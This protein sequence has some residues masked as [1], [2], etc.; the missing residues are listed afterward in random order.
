MVGGDP[1][2][3]GRAALG[4]CFSRVMTCVVSQ[5][6]MLDLRDRLCVGVF[7]PASLGGVCACV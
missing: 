5:S 2:L 3:P 7:C 4:V 1:A 6:A